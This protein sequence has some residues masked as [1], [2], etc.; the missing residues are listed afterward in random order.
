MTWRATV[1]VF[2]LPPYIRYI[3]NILKDGLNRLWEGSLVRPVVYTSLL[4]TLPTGTAPLV[5][6]QTGAAGSA[7]C[8]R[9]LRSL[10]SAPPRTAHSGEGTILVLGAH[11]DTTIGPRL[12]EN[13]L[14]SIHER[15]ERTRVVTFSRG[16][17]RAAIPG[18]SEHYT[19]FDRGNAEDFRIAVET[20]HPICIIDLSSVSPQDIALNQN[21]PNAEEFLVDLAKRQAQM[22]LEY[23]P[24]TTLYIPFSSQWADPEL[25]TRVDPEARS[26]HSLQGAGFEDGIRLRLYGRA[27][28]EFERVLQTSGRSNFVILRPVSVMS[29]TDRTTLSEQS[30]R[31]GHPLTD[32]FVTENTL[33]AVVRHL[34]REGASGQELIAVGTDLPRFLSDVGIRAE[35]FNHF[36]ERFRATHQEDA[37]P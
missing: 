6:A 2:T 35:G 30:V 18:V 1:P 36:A 33:A 21:R 28:F 12:V 14:T 3:I 13:L 9:S 32:A 31:T 7:G 17:Y 8:V 15:N 29:T 5:A 26:R 20:F 22:V 37:N 23:V 25:H 34:S 27:K 11:R 10:S 4:V 24:E 16:A 19:G